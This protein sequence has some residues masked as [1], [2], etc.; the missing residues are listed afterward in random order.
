MLEREIAAPLESHA[1][2]QIAEELRLLLRRRDQ[3]SLQASGLAGELERLGYGEAMGSVSTVDWI[4][5]ECQLGYQS[6]ADLVC[7]G[8]EMDSLADSVVA[9]QESEIGFQHLVLIARTRRALSESAAWRQ[10][11]EETPGPQPSSDASAGQVSELAPRPLPEAHLL[12]EAR[13]VSVSRF[14]HL[15]QEA[16]HA[17]DPEGVAREQG[18]AM[19]ERAFRLSQQEDGRVTLSGILDPIGGAAVKAALEP[20]GRPSGRLDRRRRE[21]RL[22][23]ALVELAQ[24]SMDQGSPRQRPHLNVTATLGTLY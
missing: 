12:A 6:A 21:R 11:M 24:H 18:R 7:V 2:D 5:H 23:D 8:L 4:R 19:E 22:A 17:A 14:R 15:C 16:R 3:I 10:A 1:S 9:V 20:L 13:E